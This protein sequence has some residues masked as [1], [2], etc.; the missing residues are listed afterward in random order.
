MAQASLLSLS[1]PD[2][3]AVVLVQDSVQQCGLASAEEASKY[4]ERNIGGLLLG[5]RDC[6]W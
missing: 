1:G 4:K 6:S 5:K 2:A 3:L